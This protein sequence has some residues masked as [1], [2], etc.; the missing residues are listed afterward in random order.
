MHIDFVMC[1]NIKQFSRVY[2]VNIPDQRTGN[3]ISRRHVQGSKI[4]K[5][6]ESVKKLKVSNLQNEFRNTRK[7]QTTELAR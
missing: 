1:K 4:A 7:T 3:G 6:H 5:G 2:N